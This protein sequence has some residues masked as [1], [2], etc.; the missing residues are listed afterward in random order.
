MNQNIGTE[1]A[2]KRWDSFADT[3][4]ANHTEQGDLHKQVFL[5]PTLL[6]LMETVRNK[7][8]LDAGC[9]EG[10]LSGC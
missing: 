7:N 8:V 2:I 4:S 3:Y 9:G 5:N 10:Y 6:S 1:E